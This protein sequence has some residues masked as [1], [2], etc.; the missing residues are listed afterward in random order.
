MDRDRLMFLV[1]FRN[2]KRAGMDHDA[3]AADA[4]EMQ[5]QVIDFRQVQSN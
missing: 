5:L 3:Y 2:R 4:A 1:V